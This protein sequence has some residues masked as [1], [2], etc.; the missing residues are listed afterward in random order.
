NQAIEFVSSY[1]NNYGK[2]DFYYLSQS[3]CL[4][5]NGNYE[6]VITLLDPVKEELNNVFVYERLS[7]A[8]VYLSRYQDALNYLDYVDFTQPDSNLDRMI[9]IKGYCHLKLD[10]YKQAID[11]FE[12]YLMEH[13]DKKIYFQCAYC[14]KQLSLFDDAYD[15]FIRAL[16]DDNLFSIA[17]EISEFD[18]LAYIDR[19]MTEFDLMEHKNY[20]YYLHFEYFNDRT[21]AIHYLT[22]F[23]E[24]QDSQDSFLQ[25]KLIGL[26]RGYKS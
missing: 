15:Y 20:F 2:D 5:M 6:E 21:S 14:F 22:L 25:N 26:N 10:E 4:F 18:S 13:D 11:A 17:Y 12:D 24:Q 23:I 8:C 3:D 16:D 9:Q 7:D 1:Q 19:F